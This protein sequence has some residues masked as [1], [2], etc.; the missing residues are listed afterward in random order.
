MERVFISKPLA[1]AALSI[2]VSVHR[3]ASVRLGGP[4]AQLPQRWAVAVVGHVAGSL[5]TEL[6]PA[7]GK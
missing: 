5:D 2:T 3:L 7:R 6:N 1:G 4:D